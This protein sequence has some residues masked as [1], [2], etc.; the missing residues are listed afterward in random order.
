MTS[1]P[2]T[3]EAPAK[4]GKVYY[5]WYVYIAVCICM[6]LACA[7]TFNTASVY[8]ESVATAFGVGLSLIHI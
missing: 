8:Y 6:F 1:Q 7:F 5:G 3:A 2:K 4:S